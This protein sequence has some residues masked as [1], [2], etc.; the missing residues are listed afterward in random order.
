MG[1][2][3]LRYCNASGADADARHV[4]DHTP[5][6]HLIPL[7]LQVPLGQ[8]DKIMVFGDDYA[9]PDGTCIRNIPAHCPVWWRMRPNRD[10]NWAGSGLFRLGAK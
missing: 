1:F 5:E 9:T 10:R 8:R 3:L 7:A 4:E 2:T 6:S